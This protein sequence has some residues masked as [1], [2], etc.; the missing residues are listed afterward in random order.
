MI[1]SIKGPGVDLASTGHPLSW[2]EGIKAKGKMW[3][4]LD[5]MTSGFESDMKN[6]LQA[7][8]HVILFQGFYEP[9]WSEPAEAQNRANFA[10]SA[11]K[12]AGYDVGAPIALDF[13]S[14][15]VDAQAA[16]VWAKTWANVVEDAGFV[17]AIYVGVPQPLDSDALY[18][19]PFQHYWKSYSGNTVEVATRGF[20]I[21]Q[22]AGSQDL[23]GVSVDIDEA[24]SDLLGD[25]MMGMAQDP[26]V[27]TPI[28]T[29]VPEPVAAN[30][31]VWH[32]SAGQ[33]LDGI[34]RAVRVPVMVLSRYNHLANPNRIDVGQ[35][36]SIPKEVRVKSG[37]TLSG[38]VDALHE[39]GITWEFIAQV[40]QINPDRLWVGQAI[41]V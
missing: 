16:E 32:V 5:L 6:A 26:V 35:V 28:P 27:E 7:G 39:P 31:P 22:S 20:Q 2:Y 12:N 37:D 36:L 34:A 24:G 40:N 33:S 1:V 18:G 29:P 19:L 3:V 13:E 38:I 21:I 25:F 15:P 11:A 30:R 8:L 17:P 9:A 23:D 10:V 4:G 14:V 41:W